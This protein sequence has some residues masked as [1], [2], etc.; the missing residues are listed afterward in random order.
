M[1]AARAATAGAVASLLVDMDQV[2]NGTVDETDGSVTFAE[3]AGADSYG[4]ADEVAR[5]VL[6]T[7]GKALGV[8]AEHMPDPGEPVAAILRYPL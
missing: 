2:V 3:A 8:R 5:R 1:R 4:V 7:G 6:Q